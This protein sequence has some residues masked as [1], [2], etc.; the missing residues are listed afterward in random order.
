VW[1]LRSQSL[2]NRPLTDALRDIAASLAEGRPLRIEVASEGPERP[3]PDLIAGNLL[4]LARE[5]L[6]NAIKHSAARN[7]GVRIVFHPKDVEV[8]VKDDGEGFDTGSHPGPRDGHFGLQ[9]M[10]ERMKRLSGA[11]IITSTPG[12]GTCIS[13]TVPAA[14]EAASSA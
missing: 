14:A 8:V 1:N 12:Q 5:A 6:T 10:R 11:L 13:A 4:L 9:G 7:I 3:L 2:E